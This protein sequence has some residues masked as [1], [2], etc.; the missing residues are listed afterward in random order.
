MERA[1]A[2]LEE[3]Q[4]SAPPVRGPD[5]SF[6]EDDL[7]LTTAVL[8]P[9]GEDEAR[10][11]W[12]DGLNT[13]ELT[14]LCQAI[15]LGDLKPR[16][17]K[18]AV[19]GVCEFLD[20]FILAKAFGRNMHKHAVRDV[21][22]RELDEDTLKV[23]QK[24]KDE[25]ESDK[26]SL[27][28]ALLA[29][30]SNHLRTVFHMN[31]VQRHS[32]ARMELPKPPRFPKQD[33]RDW[34]TEERVTGIL[35]EFDREC[36]DGM[37]SQLRDVIPWDDSTFVFIRRGCGQGHLLGADGGIFHGY[38]PEWIILHFERHAERVRISSKSQ[39]PSIAIANLLA[40]AYFDAK[41]EYQNQVAKTYTKQIQ[42]FLKAMTEDE[43]AAVSL[44]EITV[45]RCGL[46]GAP[47]L[48]LSHG[49]ASELRKA[50]ADFD[51][52]VSGG[53]LKRVRDIDGIKVGYRGKRL[54]MTFQQEANETEEFIVR[55]SEG[56]LSMMERV[57]F[58]DGMRSSYG[59]TAISNERRC[60]NAAT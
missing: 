1:T 34:F 21:A 32:F 40:S 13:H 53:L 59:I 46:R 45:N 30:D 23:C 37:V 26:H 19:I 56:R 44:V 17:R 6:W 52:K 42:H 8:K 2:E 36:G 38:T 9:Y 27:L 20:P 43:P 3:S 35:Q 4:A 39:K 50:L 25:R 51:G 16:Q 48:C 18:K 14:V 57:E 7:E 54:Q 15:G 10:A 33:F 22:R 31:M 60:A 28:F 29:T 5:T 49:V 11:K 58:E 41:V 55:Y 24:K 12:V 47:K